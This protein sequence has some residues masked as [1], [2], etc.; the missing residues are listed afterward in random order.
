MSDPQKKGQQTTEALIEAYSKSIRFD[1]IIY[2]LIYKELDL[3][4]LSEMLNKSKPTVLRHINRLV[5]LGIVSPP[6]HVDPDRQPGDKKRNYYRLMPRAVKILNTRELKNEKD[7]KKLANAVKAYSDIYESGYWILKGIIELI[8]VYGLNLKK[9][10]ASRSSNYE[11][12]KE[13]LEEEFPLFRL[14]FFNEIQFEK[15]QE[16]LQNLHA[17]LNEIAEQDDGS[18]RP[19]LYVEIVLPVKKLIEM[20][21]RPKPA[22]KTV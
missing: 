14:H 21:H 9:E 20:K 5:E 3:P 7:L 4:V 11:Q 6:Y 22:R 10:G 18:E 17:G 16:L 13:L 15:F 19:Y 1:I 2:L 12:L 8:K